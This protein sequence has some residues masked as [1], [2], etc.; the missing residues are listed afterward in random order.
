M[1]SSALEW[2]AAAY[3]L[4]IAVGLITGGRLGD[5]FGRKRMLMIGLSA[6]VVASVRVRLRVVARVADHRAG[7]P[8]PGGG[9]DHP[10]GLRTDPRPVPAGP[11]DQGVRRARAGDR[12]VDRGRSGGGRAADQ[13]RLLRLGL[14]LAVPDQRAARRIRVGRRRPG[15]A[16][17]PTRS[18]RAAPRLDGHGP[19]GDR[20]LPGGLPAGGR[21]RSG[22]AGVDL[23]RAGRGDPGAGRLRDAPA[24][25]AGAG[26][27]PASRVLAC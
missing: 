16:G 17:R 10:A 27:H 5:M 7:A 6:F 22:L 25:P 11:D 20:Q 14:A 15:A 21:P 4:A 3:T 12:A 8:G 2:I 9:A 18:S 1:T 23:R 26:S 24:A 13:R 19:D